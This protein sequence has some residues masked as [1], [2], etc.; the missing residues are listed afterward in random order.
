M[1]AQSEKPL[2]WS[3]FSFVENRCRVATPHQLTACAA[4]RF[5]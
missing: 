3:G 2:R 1:A 5:K 4:N